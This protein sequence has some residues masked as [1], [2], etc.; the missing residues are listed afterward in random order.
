MP[1]SQHKWTHP[2]QSRG[3]QSEVATLEER[4][5]RIVAVVKE[6]EEEEEETPDAVQ[7]LHFGIEAALVW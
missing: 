4:F 7:G 6:G 3:M 1:K 5:S 2:V